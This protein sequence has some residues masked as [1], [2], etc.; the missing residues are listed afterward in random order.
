MVQMT[1]SCVINGCSS[2]GV[3]RCD[4]NSAAAAVQAS[5]PLCGGLIRESLI[6]DRARGLW[7]R[8]LWK[9]HATLADKRLQGVELLLL[10]LLFK[11][12]ARCTLLLRL[13]LALLLT[14]LHLLALLLL[15]HCQLPQPPLLA[16]AQHHWPTHTALVGCLLWAAAAAWAWAAL[17]R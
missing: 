7:W 6:G 11:E 9:R 1:P 13:L 3:D 10:L 2:R 14:L 15:L 17:L 16:F 5:L 8:L 4:N 12:G